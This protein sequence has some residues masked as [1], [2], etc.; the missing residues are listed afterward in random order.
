LVEHDG[1]TWS[2]LKEPAEYFP[3]IEA[4]EHAIR[5]AGRRQAVRCPECDDTDDVDAVDPCSRCD[6]QRY[7]A[8]VRGL[9]PN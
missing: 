8:S 6:G 3:T 4:A 5:T 1:G 7:V 2:R 9:R